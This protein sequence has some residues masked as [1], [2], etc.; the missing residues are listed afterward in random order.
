MELDRLFDLA[1]HMQHNRGE[2]YSFDKK[3]GITLNY[4]QQ[5]RVVH[6]CIQAFMQGVG[7][8]TEKDVV[9]QAFYGSSALPRLTHDVFNVTQA[10]P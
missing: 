8:K 6:K 1:L 2:D 4:K 3:R 9:I 5:A 10:V 7:T